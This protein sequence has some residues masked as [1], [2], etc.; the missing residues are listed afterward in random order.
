MSTDTATRVRNRFED[1]R[2]TDPWRAVLYVV[3]FGMVGFYLGPIEI[4]LVT[5]F[6]D[7]ALSGAPFLPPGPDN[8]TLRHWTNAFESLKNGLVYSIILAVP[9]TAFSALLGSIAAYG[10]T[11]LNWRGQVAVFTLF[12]A[13]IFI[14]Y[15]AVLIPLSKLWSSYVP[16]A[17]WAAL[18]GLP[19]WAGDLAALIVTHVAYGIPITTLLFR[20]YY[21]NFSAEMIEAAR[22]DGASTAAIYRRI[23]LPLSVPMFAVTLIYQFT[24]IWNDLLFALIIVGPGEGAPV[25]VPLASLGASLTEIGFGVRMAGAF[26]AAVPTM[27]VYVLFGDKFAKGVAS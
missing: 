18:F 19:R 11:L 8:V 7:S 10:L 25:T 20:G 9:A 15:Q 2:E 14:P 4:G 24:Q 17:Q 3:L 27:I 6:K 12:V 26:I 13:G 1:L 22:L 5:A 16:L 23:I 21:K